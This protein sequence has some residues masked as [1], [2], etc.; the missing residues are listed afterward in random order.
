M[1]VHVYGLT[2]KK[3]KKEEATPR[4]QTL[5]STLDSSFFTYMCRQNDQKCPGVWVEQLECVT[6]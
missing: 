5:Q 3:K 2:I 1:H 4:T 6:L